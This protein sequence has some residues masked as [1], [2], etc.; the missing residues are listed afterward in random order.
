MSESTEPQGENPSFSDEELK[1]IRE[2]TGVIH[3]SHNFPR[4]SNCGCIVM[5]EAGKTASCIN[6]N[7]ELKEENEK[8]HMYYLYSISLNG[9]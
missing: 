7:A 8:I 4:C 5:I 9:L 1:Q 2:T 3:H 6:C